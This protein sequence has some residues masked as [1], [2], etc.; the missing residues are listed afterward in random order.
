MQHH[1]VPALPVAATADVRIASLE[2]WGEIQTA[3]AGIGNVTGVTVTAMDMNYARI[4]LGYMGGVEQLREAVGAAGLTIGPF[5]GRLLDHP[6]RL[7]PPLPEPA[8]KG[9]R[10][11]NDVRTGERPRPGQTRDR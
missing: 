10:Q 6:H 1:A 7:P 4:N 3:L 8:Q 11:Q 9:E 5:A 2:Q